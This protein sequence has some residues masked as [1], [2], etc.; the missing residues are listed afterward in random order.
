MSNNLSTFVGIMVFTINMTENI[1]HYNIGKSNGNGNGFKM[2]LPPSNDLAKMVATS[3]IAGG[4]V[5]VFTK[6]IQLQTN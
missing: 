5:A 2:K 4:I 1:V 3:I 6:Y